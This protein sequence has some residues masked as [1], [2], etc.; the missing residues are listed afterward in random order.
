MGG[1]WG[2]YMG[3]YRGGDGV[4]RQDMTGYDRIWGPWGPGSARGGCILL[5][6]N[7]GGGRASWAPWAPY[8]IISGHILSYHPISPPISPHLCPPYT[9]HGFYDFL[10][11]PNSACA[12]GS[13]LPSIE[14]SLP[15]G[16]ARCRCR[17][18]RRPP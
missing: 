3:G 11:S 10:Y 5:I 13:Y 16:N 1:I 14:L 4:I 6:V 15:A 17:R 12:W 2:A 7:F 18:R 9:P 8:P